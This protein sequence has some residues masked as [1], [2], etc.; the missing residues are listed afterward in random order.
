MWENRVRIKNSL[1]TSPYLLIY[2]HEPV[3]PINL[4][5]LLLKFM[6]AY[7]ED[8]DRVK[9]KLMNLLELDEKMSITLEHM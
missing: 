7:Y 6:G 2:G 1:G 5:I 8:G 4:K 3:F 9:V